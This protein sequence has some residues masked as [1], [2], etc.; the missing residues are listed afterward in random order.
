MTKTRSRGQVDHLAGAGGGGGERL[1]DQQRLA[2]AAAPRARRRGAAGAGSRRRGRRRPVVGQDLGVGAV[3]PLDAVR[4]AKAWAR[5]SE[6]EATATSSRAVDA[7]E[8]LDHLLGDAARPDDAP[9]DH[10][11]L[12]HR[13]CAHARHCRAGPARRPAV[14]SVADGSAAPVQALLLVGDP[15]TF[16]LA[17]GLVLA[18][19]HRDDHRHEDQPPEVLPARS[20]W[21]R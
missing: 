4:S 18:G 11:V 1:L 16:A 6:R 15:P 13:P 2:R 9:A 7:R 14:T 17:V 20:G 5:S 3:G 21:R 8:V 19:H 10:A 12:V